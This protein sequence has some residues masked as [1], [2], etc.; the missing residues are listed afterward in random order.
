MKAKIV[1]TFDVISVSRKVIKLT[2]D[3]KKIFNIN[4]PNKQMQKKAKKQNVIAVTI[5]DYKI[6]SNGT[7]DIITN[8]I[9]TLR[10]VEE[11]GIC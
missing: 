7:I 6:K 3:S 2:G 8:E 5:D 11:N 4:E 1:M 9:M 10:E